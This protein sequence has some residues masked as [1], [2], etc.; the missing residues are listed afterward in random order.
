MTSPSPSPF[1]GDRLPTREGRRVRLRWLEAKDVP[2]LFE[3]F[4]DPEVMRYWSRPPMT[5]EGEAAALLAQTQRRFAARTDFQ[6]GIA[7]TLDDRI[8]GTCTLFALNV[9][10]ER[11]EVG[12]ALGR[13][14]WGQGLMAE[15]QGLL[16]D[17]AFETL[18]LRRLEADVDPRN[19]RSLR[20]LERLGFKREGYARER[21]HV[22]GEIQDAVLLGLLK[23]E[24]LAPSR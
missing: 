6:W 23:R 1:S 16:L 20:S 2:A 12:Y 9:E 21:W 11:A 19:T 22:A 18:G 4:S 17:Q 15:A 8:I 14:H 3:V 13:A 5:D 10:N 24:R 7:R